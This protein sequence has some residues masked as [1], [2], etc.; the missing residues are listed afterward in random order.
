MQQ[1]SDKNFL[2]IVYKKLKHW[3]D[4]SNCDRL[5]FIVCAIKSL[6]RHVDQ[7]KTHVT[8]TCQKSGRPA[9]GWPAGKALRLPLCVEMEQFSLMLNRCHLIISF[10]VFQFEHSVKPIHLY[11]V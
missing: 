5:Q 6:K 9:V 7:I 4:K 11:V 2:E 8:I 3:S 10:L 1:K